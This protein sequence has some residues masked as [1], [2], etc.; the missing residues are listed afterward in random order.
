[1]RRLH[2]T[3]GKV[4]Q[5][6]HKCKLSTFRSSS[7]LNHDCKK[8][9]GNFRHRLENPKTCSNFSSTFIE[10]PKMNVLKPFSFILEKG[11]IRLVVNQI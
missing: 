6:P 5:T 11:G 9:A 1:M 10:A 2:P 8:L 7:N 4:L 3:A